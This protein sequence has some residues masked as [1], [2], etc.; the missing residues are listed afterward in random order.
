MARA[1]N[2]TRAAIA[3]GGARVTELAWTVGRDRRK[4]ARL[5][6][7]WAVLQVVLGAAFALVSRRLA[8]RAWVVLTGEEPPIL[9]HDGEP[10]KDLGQGDL[11]GEDAAP[12]SSKAHSTR[13]PDAG[14]STA[15]SEGPPRR[16]RE[17]LVEMITDSRRSG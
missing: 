3:A 12:A 11:E 6:R 17:G 4:E 2:Q 8:E 10:A 5:Q 14:G 1:T 16:P 15:M 13:A 9:G 7:R